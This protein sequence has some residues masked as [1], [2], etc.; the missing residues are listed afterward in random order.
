MPLCIIE[1]I[2]S[3]WSFL[4]ALYFVICPIK[5]RKMTKV[6]NISKFEALISKGST[7]SAK[8]CLEETDVLS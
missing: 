5:R 4:V 2:I 6:L 1:V 7:S 3:L 8:I